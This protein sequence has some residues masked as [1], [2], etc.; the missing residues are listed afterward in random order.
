MVPVESKTLILYD[1]T[2]GKYKVMNKEMYK[3]SVEWGELKTP[4]YIFDKDE[5]VYRA[6]KIQS[7]LDKFQG[8]L[9][10]AIKANPF[11]VPYLDSFLSKYE[12]CSP[13][14]LEI[15]R[16]Y[17]ISGE[18]I[19]FS[20]VVKSYEDMVNALNYPV[21]VI[22]I[23]SLRHWE[24]LKE[25]VINT[26]KSAKV[27][28]RLTSGA[29]FGMEEEDI[30][31]ILKE[32]NELSGIEFEGIHYFT[33]TQKK[34]AK[35]E[36]ELEF[37]TE[38]MKEIQ[39]EFQREQ[40]T[41]EYGPGL[42]VPYFTTDSFEE[43]FGI[44]EDMA[45]YIKNSAIPYKMVVELG[46]YVASTCGSYVTRIVDIKKAGERKYCMVDGG[47]HHLNYYGQNMAMR[48]PIIKHISYGEVCE[49]RE[50]YMIC[51]SLCTFAD[52]LVRALPLTKPEINDILIFENCGAYTVTEASYL[53]L[54]RDMPSIYIYQKESGLKMIRENLA[55]WKINIEDEK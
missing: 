36:K 35:Y 7:I 47:I 15:C 55:T 11:L 31:K 13:G 21:D 27:L 33:G 30:R 9:C 3:G 5:V 43:P 34:G 41:L 2:E 52:I 45:E 49:E 6:Q 19:V 23:E 42:A 28:L 22:T 10:Y 54:S 18:K 26:G 48:T 25:A 20:G 37:V 40:M 1:R 4:Y 8:R 24:L 29:Q 14:E 50:E 38:F 44:V 17:H 12:V 32:K 39:Q 51:G 46:R 53:F 16:H